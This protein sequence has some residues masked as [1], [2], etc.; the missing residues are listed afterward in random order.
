VEAKA[1][2]EF[3]LSLAKMKSIPRSGWI[4][5]GVSLQDVESVADHS[6]STC[7]LSLLIADLETQKGKHVRVER[8]MQMALFHDLSE[9][10]TFDISK[11][12]LEYLGPKGESIKRELDYSAW[13]HIINLL[14]DSALRREYSG[15]EKEFE[16]GKTYESKIVHSADKLDILLQVLEYRRKGYP[17]Y[18]LAE[19]WSGTSQQL[20]SC[21]IP[22]A[23]LIQKILAREARTQGRKQ[24]ALR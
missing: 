10:L 18:L 20:R 12:Y 4:A 9:S 16:A 11:E 6:F 13:K 7:L 24:R 15:I 2:L 17:E 3:L 23:V 14:Q 5:H 8:V 22:S 1:I 19:L 21:M